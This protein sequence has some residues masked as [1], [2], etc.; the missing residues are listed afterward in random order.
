MWIG[1]EGA[2][3]GAA[4]LGLHHRGFHLQEVP[5]LHEPADQADD[6]APLVKHLADFGIDDQVEMALAV[7][8]LDIREAVPLLRQGTER[9][10]EQ[11]EAVLLHVDRQFPGPGLED[12]PR[13]PDDVA[14]IEPFKQ[15][16]GLLPQLVFPEEG[17]ET[18]LAVL[19]ADEGALAEIADGHQAARQGESFRD[20]FQLFG[21]HRPEAFADR[22]RGIRDPG[23]VGIEIDPVG[24]QGVDLFPAFFQKFTFFFFH[25]FFDINSSASSVFDIKWI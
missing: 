4:G 21:G 13:K 14:D 24:L 16:K 15:R 10:G 5:L 1:L 6:A 3:D 25:F 12:P 9:F 18:P 23:V 11:A 17:L 19:D 8:D 20:L 7:A 22:G 2:G